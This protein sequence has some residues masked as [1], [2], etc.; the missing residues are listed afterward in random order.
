MKS[1]FPDIN[2]WVALAYGGHQHHAIAIS[3]LNQVNSAVGF[4]RFTQLGFLRFMT[5]PVVMQTEVKTQLEAWKA[6]DLFISDSR[7]VFYPESDMERVE[8]LFRKLTA[9]PQFA[10]QQWSDAYLAAFAKAEDL[11][12][13]TFDRALSTLAG[14]DVLFLKPSAN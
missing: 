5:H 8:E 6:Y 10:P 9:M 1:Y 4:S 3:W 12:L 7:V 14:K 13:V 2:V 11:T